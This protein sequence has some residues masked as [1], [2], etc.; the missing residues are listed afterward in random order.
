MYKLQPKKINANRLAACR[1]TESEHN[2]LFRWCESQGLTVSEFLQ[3]CIFSR[4]EKL[5]QKEIK[6]LNQMRGQ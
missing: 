1:L 4:P 6:I 2:D 5:T 3:M